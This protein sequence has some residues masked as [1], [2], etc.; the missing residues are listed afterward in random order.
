M[1]TFSGYKTKTFSASQKFFVLDPNTGGP[2]FVQGSDLVAQITPNSNYVYSE[3]T[4]TTAQATDY[5]IGSVIQTSGAESVGDNE[6]AVY[7]VVPSGEGDFPMDNGNE[8][9]V[10]AGDD[11]LREQL[12]LNTTGNG[13]DRIAHTGTS[14]TVTE[15]LDKRVIRVSSRTEMKAYDVPAGYQFSLEEGGR[16]GKFVVKSGTPPADTEEGVY[17]VLDNGNYAERKVDGPLRAGFF[18]ADIA[19]S[20]NATAIQAMWDFVAASGYGGAQIE[21][22]FEI[23]APINITK[24]NHAKYINVVLSGPGNLRKA[25]GFTGDRLVNIASNFFDEDNIVFF[26]LSFDGVDKT[27]NGVDWFDETVAFD[28]NPTT[29]A[30][31]TYAKAIRFD[32]CNFNRC[33]RGSRVSGNSNTFA[34]CTY[35]E[36][37]CG[38]FNTAAAN[39]IRYIGCSFR[40][41]GVGAHIKTA[42]ASLGTV[43][44][45]FLG[46]I[47]ESN[48]I[49]GLA[50]EGRPND[51]GIHGFY[52]ENN[53]FNLVASAY[54][55]ITL[56]GKACHI[57]SFGASDGGGL[58]TLSSGEFWPS[59][60]GVVHVYGSQIS[61][62]A[63]IN[64]PA[65]V[66]STNI[67]SENSAVGK[68]DLSSV[69]ISGAT[70]AQSEVLLTINDKSYYA[71][72]TTLKEFFPTELFQAG[73]STTQTVATTNINADTY[74]II[75]ENGAN[76]AVK[77][78]AHRGSSTVVELALMGV[79]TGKPTAAWSGDDLQV[80]A[81]TAGTNRVV[82]KK[83]MIR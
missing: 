12:A 80:T 74:E 52:F 22:D 18:G 54:T 62:F 5:E 7:V 27:V 41:G 64:T 11:T 31:T 70:V 51:V 24:E 43:G 50:L 17:V 45:Q 67:F 23:E 66:E 37:R 83:V 75:A 73:P 40:R 77:L 20:T 69:D 26:H 47:F 10:L 34:S 44:T 78:I 63:F 57:F 4:R 65:T 32:N 82:V 61:R 35:R 19:S 60:A 55:A 53:G 3:A 6:A 15:A 56:P 33:Y 2:A 42:S 76:N 1:S 25:A 58:T 59:P 13:S 39:D 68:F 9:L 21:K 14:D 46:C 36:N 38:T 30:D 49:T 79:S 81:G 16:S 48:E 29:V 8:L 71:I 28:A 72:G